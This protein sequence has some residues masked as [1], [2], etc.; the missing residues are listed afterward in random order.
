MFAFWL[1]TETMIIDLAILKSKAAVNW[2]ET[3]IRKMRCGLIAIE[4]EG[5]GFIPG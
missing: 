5:K 3:D 2:Y 4:T 1:E